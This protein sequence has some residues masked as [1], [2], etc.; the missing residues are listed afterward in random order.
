MSTDTKERILAVGEDLVCTKSFHS[1]GLNEIL[2]AAK[3]PKGSF[4]HYFAS[5]EAFG[6]ELIRHYNEECSQRWNRLMAPHTGLKPLERLL[7]TLEAQLAMMAE[8]GCQQSCLMV[9]L[10]AEVSQLS[11]P[12]RGEVERILVEW[13][14]SWENL[15]AEGQDDGDIRKDIPAPVLASFVQS[16][17]LGAIVRAHVEKSF[18]PLRAAH[19]AIQGYL[20]SKS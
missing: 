3:V 1:V 4:Y 7:T 19:D 18:A 10:A 11:E 9:K 12:M 8:Q 15:I 6:V 2:A 5:K 13:R 14:L 17:W 16:A 20:S